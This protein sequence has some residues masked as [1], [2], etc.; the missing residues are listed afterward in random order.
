MLPSKVFR[1]QVEAVEWLKSEAGLEL[2]T[3]VQ[4][5]RGLPR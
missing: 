4:I 1:S 5:N 2:V 3:Y